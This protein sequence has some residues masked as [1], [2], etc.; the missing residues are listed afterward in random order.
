MSKAY[1]GMPVVA[2]LSTRVMR[3]DRIGVMG[4]NR[5][6][7]TTLQRRLVGE[8]QPDTGTLH[9]GT[10]VQ[11]AYFDQD[12]AAL[13][14]EQTVVDAVAGGSDTVTVGG[15]SRHVH[16]YLQ[17][18]LF[19]PERLRSPVKAL[20]GGERN[21]LM[22]ARLLTRPANVLVFDE[23]TNDLDIETLEVVEALLADFPGTILLV[24]HDRTFLD[25]VVTSTLVF[26]G[27]GRIEEY[28]GGYE[29]WRRHKL[30]T[31]PVPASPPAPAASAPP[32]LSA[33]PV[34]RPRKL[35]YK[36]RRE[37]EALPERDRGARGGGHGP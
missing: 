27:D 37:F 16:G 28:V 5:G 25:N 2:E 20:S 18:F 21:R 8:L 1:A 17:D 34:V 15:V 32:D 26:E 4:P 33:R 9:V 11:V 10:N 6:G 22:L 35:S 13:D 31:T 12:R 23:P 36:E 24:S 7:K 19:P 29:D 14:P 30:A 3:G